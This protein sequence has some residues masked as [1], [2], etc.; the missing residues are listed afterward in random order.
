MISDTAAT[1]S[2][3]RKFLLGILLIGMTGTLT[4]LL[5]LRHVEDLLQLIPLALIA[6]GYAAVVWHAVRRSRI[7]IIAVQA[8]MLCYVAAGGLGVFLHYRANVEFQ[9]E[10]QP[11]LSGSNLWWKVLQAKTPPALAPGVMAQLGLIGLAYAYRHPAFAPG[12]RIL[13]ENRDE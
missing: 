3:L 13:E 4:E 7:S 12:R 10:I 5:L 9:L 6:V 2:G 1:V 11:E 8:V